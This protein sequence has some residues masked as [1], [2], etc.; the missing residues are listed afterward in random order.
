M[1]KNMS[2]ASIALPSSG[3]YTETAVIYNLTHAD[4][5]LM[6]HDGN[7][8]IIPVYKGSRPTFPLEVNAEHNIDPS[9][10]GVVFV[11]GKGVVH[12]QNG[13]NMV[14]GV[15]YEVV[16]R[17]LFMRE[18]FYISNPNVN[19][20]IYMTAHGTNGILH[21]RAAK[22]VNF[23]SAIP[24]GEM[25]LT[26]SIFAPLTYAD[27]SIDCLYVMSP[28][29]TQPL[30]IPVQLV[31]RESGNFE[32]VVHSK[33]KKMDG[34]N[35]IEGEYDTI[36]HLKEEFTYGVD[37]N[38]IFMKLPNHAHDFMVISPHFDVAKINYCKHRS[39]L[40]S[41]FAKS[42]CSNYEEVSTLRK[43]IATL[44]DTV[45]E[46]SQKITDLNKDVYE[47][48]NT[49]DR[50][51][52]IDNSELK[53]KQLD[54]EKLKAELDS[55]KVEDAKKISNDNVKK[56]SYGSSAASAKA[57]GETWKSAVTIG[58]VAA[59]CI[60][61]TIGILSA[62]GVAAAPVVAATGSGAAAGSLATAIGSSVAAVG[63]DI[64]SSIGSAVCGLF[65]IF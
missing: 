4:I 64:I 17:S 28:M 41:D 38:L 44:N 48:Q 19:K 49:I 46:K 63:S 37:D 1:H 39:D 60:A 54:N 55:K 15:S 18:A 7:E 56:A 23:T 51:M 59:A 45:N 6:D 62:V 22:L 35:F 27:R 9:W 24:D 52:A 13:Y 36:V 50:L 29:T 33:I 65:S 2:G 11:I 16:H 32:L 25:G 43:T 30:R 3:M 21:P 34:V 57:T 53:R 47:Q 31:A 61:G 58:G 20:L 40:L 12:N 5:S 42:S 26:I 8:Q 14:D 10:E